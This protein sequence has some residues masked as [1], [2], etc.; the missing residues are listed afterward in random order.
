M[1][2]PKVLTAPLAVIKINGIAVGKMKNIRV[3]ESIR[4]GKVTGLGKLTP[5]ELPPTEWDGSFSCSS[6]TIDF[7]K[8]FNQ[9]VKDKNDLSFNSREFATVDEFVDKMTITDIGL[10]IS[11][12]R[13]LG[14]NQYETFAKINQ[15][16]MTREGFDI[17]EGQISGRDGEFQYL[18][19]I[20]YSV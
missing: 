19:P 9:D 20:L 13:K 3:V 8:L 17:Q 16:Y 6:Y 7:K 10:E 15:A 2:Q 18:E 1:A 11:L 12:Q 4:R 5:S 14:N